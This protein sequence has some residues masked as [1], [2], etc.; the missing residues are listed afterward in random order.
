[1]DTYIKSVLYTNGH[2]F[3]KGTTLA[4][5]TIIYPINL[6]YYTPT[7]S[8]QITSY[9]IPTSANIA[10]VI[11]TGY[12]ASPTWSGS[13][14]SGT[15]GASTLSCAY[16]VIPST[17]STTTTIGNLLGFTSGNYPAT[18]TGLSN[19]GAYT[20]TTTSN[21]FSATPPFSP[22]GSIINAIIISCDQITN[23]ITTPTNLLATVPI[24]N[25]S[26][27]SN[28]NFTPPTNTPVKLKEGRFRSIRF[29]FLDQNLN[30]INA[31]DP[32]ILLTFYIK[33]NLKQ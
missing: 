24:V 4:D 18:N 10:T 32:N 27:G 33:L 28:I 16:F 19:T 14:P 29:Q 9:S 2:Y 11:G 22:Q 17:T 7:Y 6:S 25:T 15:Y 31:L 5:T 21:S 8:I 1:L 12:S 30:L 20:N 13:Y 3:V 23:E 26:Y